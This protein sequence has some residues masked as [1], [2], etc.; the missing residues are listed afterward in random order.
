MK[1]SR[2]QS[3]IIHHTKNKEDLKYNI[4]SLYVNIEM[5]DMW[6]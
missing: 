4:Y 3:E 2:F 5:T 6:E 1:I